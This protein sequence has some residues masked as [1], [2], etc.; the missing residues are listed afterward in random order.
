MNKVTLR[1]NAFKCFRNAAFELRNMTILT[2][3]NAAGKSSVIQALWLLKKIAEADRNGFDSVHIDD[4][5]SVINLGNVSDLIHVAERDSETFALELDDCKVVVH[6]SERD[7]EVAEFD[8]LGDDTC[9]D[10][11]YPN[12]YLYLMAERIGPRDESFR[13]PFIKGNVNCG[14]SGT[15]TASIIDGNYMATVDA[16]RSLDEAD[17]MDKFSVLLDAWV[18]YIFPGISVRV[19]NMSD[20]VCKIVMRSRVTGNTDISAPNIGFGISYALPILVEA[21]LVPKGGW[22]VIENPEVHLHAKAQS[23]LGYF[24][25]VI[26][27]SGVRVVLETHSEHIVDGVRRALVCRGCL[28]PEDVAIYF[29]EAKNEDPANINVTCIEMDGDGNL[30]DSPVDFFD[31]VRQ[32]MMEIISTVRARKA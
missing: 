31:Q 15:Y 30:S 25:G 20:K 2:G 11:V 28:K 7:K 17:K 23:N 19:V 18:D 21:L 10:Q 27:A 14:I 6:E 16:A 9:L 24:L 12:D 22:L 4:M 13:M 26:A 3:A 32:D 5:E 29:M 8:V 1:L